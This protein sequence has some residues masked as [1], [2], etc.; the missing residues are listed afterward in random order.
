MANMVS[1]VLQILFVYF[2]P[3]SRCRDIVGK[4]IIEASSHN[5]VEVQSGDDH[6]LV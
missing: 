5:I 2:I 3:L 6:Q 4:M 1:F